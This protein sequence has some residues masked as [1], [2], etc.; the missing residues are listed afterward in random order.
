MPDT[1]SPHEVLLEL[2]SEFA[3]ELME[4]DAV[5]PY[6]REDR[7]DPALMPAVVLS[8]STAVSTVVA[9]KL[10][11]AVAKSLAGAVR[12]WLARRKEDDRPTLRSPAAGT[13]LVI[14]ADTTDEEIAA[15]LLHVRGDQ[16]DQG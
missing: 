3:Y 10:S 11:E 2:P 1:D 8:V 4:Q 14:D 15:Y 6:I 16:S 12:G 13:T 9:T 5:W 7:V